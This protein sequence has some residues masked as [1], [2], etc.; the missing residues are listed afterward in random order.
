MKFSLR[1]FWNLSFR[2][3]WE[4]FMFL[5]RNLSSS[6]LP[7]K[8][9]RFW[10]TSIF[11][12]EK[13]ILRYSLQALIIRVRATYRILACI[14]WHIYFPC[15]ITFSALEK[16]TFHEKN[17]WSNPYDYCRRIL[18][19]QILMARKTSRIENPRFL[20]CNFYLLLSKSWNSGEC[21]YCWI[22]EGCDRCSR[23]T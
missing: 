20:L 14:F 16:T 4:L 18:K 11:L 12:I 23:S 2:Q 5:L 21:N 17:P 10:Q 3:F 19:A 15:G 22:W 7:H 13:V 8:Q 1:T 9:I 6:A